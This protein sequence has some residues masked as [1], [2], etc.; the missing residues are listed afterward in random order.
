MNNSRASQDAGEG[1]SRECSVVSEGDARSMW[2]RTALGKLGQSMRFLETADGAELLRQ[3]RAELLPRILAYARTMGVSSAWLCG[4]DVMHA[5]IV[6]LCEDG[7]RRA[8]YIAQFAGDPW[9]YLERCMRSWAQEQW[10][11]RCRSFEAISSTGASTE[12]A[13]W[14]AAGGQVSDV[15]A[16]EQRFEHELT[17][18]SDAV[19]LVTR[20]L[21][22]YVAQ[23][24]QRELH[25]LVSWLARNYPQRRSY[26]REV[27]DAAAARF[28]LWAPREI[29]AVSNIVWGGRPRTRETSLL[30]AYLL[31][32]EFRVSDSFTHA[33][34]VVHFAREMRAAARSEIDTDSLRRAA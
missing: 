1:L 26:E 33:R 14:R 31:D 22:P 15:V 16:P 27:R 6:R 24:K 17:A 19:I 8:N 34:A 2:R 18:L 11:T 29:A 32:A 25:S 21:A 10:G 5:L 13:C 7:G 3:I 28:L 12:L 23:P 20:T 4:D 9:P 30:A